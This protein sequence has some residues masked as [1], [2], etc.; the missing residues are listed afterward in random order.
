MCGWFNQGV[1]E[2][3]L[4]VA[5]GAARAAAEVVRQNFGATIATEWKGDANPVTAVDRAAEAAAVALIRQGFPDDAIVAEESAEPSDHPWQ[6]ARAWLVDPLDGTVNF[7]HS[8]PQVAVSVALWVHGKP[9]AAVIRDVMKGEEFTATRGGG[10]FLGAGR[11]AVSEEKELTAGLIATGFPYD[12]NRRGAEYARNLGDVLTRSQGVRRFG[13]AALDLAWVAAG[14]FDG[15][16]EFGLSP[17]DA[18]AGILIVTEAGGRV[19][20]AAGADYRLGEWGVVASNGLVHGDLL[21]AI[22]I[23]MPTASR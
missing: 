20:N 17:W 12:R 11:L 10:A 15:Y 9:A 2:A 22:Q 14:R 13:S 4:V 3:D 19:S 21:S 6:R 23:S 7:I 16:W 18:A 5:I 1:Y 8:V